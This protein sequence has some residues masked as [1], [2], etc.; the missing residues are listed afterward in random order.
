MLQLSNV[1][2]K[3][4]FE[5]L[6]S[7]DQRNENH[8]Q[9]VDIVKKVNKWT[10]KLCG[11]KQSLKTVIFQGS[12]KECRLNVQKL[13]ESRFS[14]ERN[15]FAGEVDEKSN[16]AVNVG[17][18]NQTNWAEFLESDDE[19]DNMILDGDDHYLSNVNSEVRTTCSDDTRLE[20]QQKSK[21]MS[22][23]N[24]T[25]PTS[26]INHSKEFESLK[27]HTTTQSEWDQFLPGEP[28]D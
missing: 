3:N 12:G 19:I 2:G 5:S 14:A 17:Q 28:S 1:P 6:Q 10:C 23:E 8:F 4:S 18:R 24:I 9:Q 11:E 15:Q 16:V 7:N 21:E 27:A 22:E 20:Y 26:I 25:T 13:N